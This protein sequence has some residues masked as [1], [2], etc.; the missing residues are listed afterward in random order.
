MWVVFNMAVNFKCYH[1]FKVDESN[2]LFVRDDNQI[3]TCNS[4]ASLSIEIGITEFSIIERIKFLWIDFC[5]LI[6]IFR[7]KQFA[8]LKERIMPPLIKRIEKA[9]QFLIQN[10]NCAANNVDCLEDAKIICLG[11]V[12]TE[13]SHRKNNGAVID[14]I[15]GMSRRDIL[16]EES[17]PEKIDHSQQGKYVKKFIERA[18]WDNRP[19]KLRS[20]GDSILDIF[21][22]IRPLIIGAGVYGI[23]FPSDELGYISYAAFL[24]GISALIVDIQKTQ[25]QLGEFLGS[26]QNMCKVI[27]KNLR[28]RKVF[29][30]AGSAHLQIHP[31][32]E[33][34]SSQG[35]KELREYLNR[36]KHIILIPK[37][38]FLLNFN[39]FLN[40]SIISLFR[41]INVNLD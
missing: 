4:A 8:V 21:S 27:G 33:R 17:T 12:H 31:G 34:M 11:E 30:I 19:P 41:K 16:I 20:N 35:V 15:I 32:Y 39:N 2:L 13:D 10:Y 6:P 37:Y 3:A 25:S 36:E 24:L 28:R 29:V 23:F 1:C 26:N 40:R 9:N 14:E 7:D 38:G 18:G 22:D 5:A